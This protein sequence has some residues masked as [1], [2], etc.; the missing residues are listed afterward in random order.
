ML[1]LDFK[2]KGRSV[3]PDRMAEELTKA[4]KEEALDAAKKTITSVRCPVHGTHPTQIHVLT[5]SGQM[6]FRYEACCEE[7]ESAIRTQLPVEE[8]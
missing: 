8:D 4:I 3:H 5:E 6:R 2:V 7:L 1:K